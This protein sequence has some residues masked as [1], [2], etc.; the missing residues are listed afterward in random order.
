MLMVRCY[1]GVDYYREAGS[2]ADVEGH[3]RPPFRHHEAGEQ[4]QGASRH[5]PRH[6]GAC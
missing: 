3:R 4:P 6:I 2:A 1:F 5:V